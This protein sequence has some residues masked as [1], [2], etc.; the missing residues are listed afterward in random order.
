M[1]HRAAMGQRADDVDEHHEHEYTRA[2]GKQA[3][4]VHE[5]DSTNHAMAAAIRK[6]KAEAQEIVR[7]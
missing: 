5:F 7:Q 3:P 1:G 2:A 4:E 6:A